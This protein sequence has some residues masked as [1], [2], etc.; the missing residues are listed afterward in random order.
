MFWPCRLY[1]YVATSYGTMQVAITIATVNL[2]IAPLS[3]HLHSI[4]I[5][6]SDISHCTILSY[7]MPHNKLA[8]N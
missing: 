4:Y 1:S 8:S 3:V 7:L 6:V 5:H 2:A